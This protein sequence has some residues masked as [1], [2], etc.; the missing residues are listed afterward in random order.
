MEKHSDSWLIKTVLFGWLTSILLFSNCSTTKQQLT[1]QEALHAQVAVD[2]KDINVLMRGKMVYEEVCG[3]CHGMKGEGGIANNLTD[4]YWVYGNRYEDI[5]EITTYGMPAKGKMSF[6]NALP[7][8]AISDVAI[9]IMSLEGTEPSEQKQPEGKL[10]PPSYTYYQ[11]AG[12][13][14]AAKKE[15]ARKKEIS[16]AYKRGET[17]ILYF[18]ASWCKQCPEL[19]AWLQSNDIPKLPTIHLISIETTREPE[20]VNDFKLTHIP[21]LIRVDKKGRELNRQVLSTE[22][23]WTDEQLEATFIALMD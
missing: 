9:Y 20:K 14:I 8:Q 16:S 4:Y 6:K 18:T 11:K 1:E 7:K 17:P 10:Y 22:A 2:L 3:I 23:P 21:T 15:Q 5:V 12:E 19:P 13:E